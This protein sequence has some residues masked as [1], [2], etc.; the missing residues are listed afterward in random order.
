M[1]RE[2]Q[3]A[4][5]LP[6][7]ALGF[8]LRALGRVAPGRA[9]LALARRFCT[10]VRRRGEPASDLYA[11][12]GTVDHRGLRLPVWRAGDGPTVL[13]AHGWD[14]N[15]AF[16]DPMA[17]SLVEAG[18][19]VVAFD[20][21]A[22][23]SAEG[24]RTNV[25]DMAAAVRGV[26]EKV[27]PLAAVVGHSAGGAATALALRDGLDAGRGVLIGVP[28]LPAA[29][30]HPLAAAL[31]LPRERALAALGAME[32]DVGVDPWSADTVAAVREARVP[33]L[34]IHDDDDRRAPWAD[35][36]AVAVAWGGPGARLVT[37][38]GLGHYRLAADPAVL[39]EVREFVQGSLA[40]AAQ[41]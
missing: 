40:S 41:R 4:V 32:R 39:A 12:A 9:D 20:M 1:S 36:R 24:K 33:G 21:P 17:R 11:P 18:C 26:A 22:H 2:R 16:F 29:F 14:G 27:G 6:V 28:A 25:I 34:V 19:A 15:A 3:R 37:T 10:P 31:G 23:G 5:P 30:I 13:L 35:G 8:W 38:Q 7:R